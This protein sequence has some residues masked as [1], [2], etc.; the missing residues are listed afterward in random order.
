MMKVIIM[1]CLSTWAAIKKCRNVS[2]M[3]ASINPS[4]LFV[5]SRAFE[6]CHRLVSVE[7]HD[8][9]EIIEELAFSFCYS[10]RGMKLSGVRVIEEG[11]FHYCRQLAD[12]KFGDKLDTI[13]EGA[14]LNCTS[15]RNI[16]V[17][18]VRVI[19]EGAFMACEQLTEAELPKNLERIEGDAFGSCPRLRRIA[20]PLKRHL[21]D[22]RGY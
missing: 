20:F 17:L 16:K 9:V 12:V 5:C 21:F 11:A 1:M 18:S 7:M 10:L 22:A 19:G 2:L 14:F 3:S 13:G 4:K 8:G 15:L 6:E